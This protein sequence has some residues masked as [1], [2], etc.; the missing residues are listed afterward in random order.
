MFKP[1]CNLKQSLNE[2]N[3][4]DKSKQTDRDRDHSFINDDNN[5][6]IQFVEN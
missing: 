4:Q 3:F 6:A 2:S 5:V 1:R